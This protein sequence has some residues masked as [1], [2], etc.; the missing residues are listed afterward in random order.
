LVSVTFDDGQV[1]QYDNARP[2]LAANGI[3]ATFYLISAYLG[4]GAYM[5]AAQARTLQ[6][7]G[8]EI[9]SHSATH[10]NLTT[11][12]G[13]RLTAELAGSKTT[14]EA[15]FGPIRS[16]AYPFGA[17]NDAV[18]AAAAQVYQTART[19]DGG[20]NVPGSV[21]RARLRMRYVTSGTDAATVAGWMSEAANAGAWTIL[22]YHG[23]DTTGGDYSVT[24]A[25]FAAHMAAVKASGLRTLTVSDAYAAVS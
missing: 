9:G 7:A 21:D 18:A 10:A 17:Y 4:S 16:L 1:N 15:S 23:V 19:T 25:Q 11:L 6:A 8:H 14:L 24:P 22:V 2:V 12:S 13:D 20:V 5:S 3:P